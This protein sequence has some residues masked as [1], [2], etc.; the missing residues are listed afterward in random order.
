MTLEDLKEDQ[1]PIDAPGG[2]DPAPESTAPVVE[3]GRDST[4]QA[5]V[6]SLRDQLA[7]TKSEADQRLASL[8]RLL[9]EMAHVRTAPNPAPA[10]PVDWDNDPAAGYKLAK[11]EFTQEL[12]N[13]RRESRAQN[14]ALRQRE[15]QANIQRINADNPDVVKRF[16]A[17]IDKYYR[18]FPNERF[19][20]DS[21]ATVVQ[22]YKGQLYDEERTRRRA[23]APTSPNPVAPSGPSRPAPEKPKLSDAEMRL[24]RFYGMY[25]GNKTDEQVAEEWN[26]I[27][28]DRVKYPGRRAGR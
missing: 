14:E 5:E 22:Y 11:R 13:L 25:D 16:Q 28:E 7:R 20:P 19:N 9:L 4:S 10:E 1:L 3:P 23:T 21:Y 24:A 8:E 6:E 17:D 18:D 27:R 26:T 2:G 15:L 12:E